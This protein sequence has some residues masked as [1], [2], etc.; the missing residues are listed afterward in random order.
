M[1]TSEEIKKG[2]ECCAARYKC[3][4]CPYNESDT[5]RGW[6]CNVKLNEDLL[7]YVQRLETE[8]D[9]VKRERDAAVEAAQPKWISVE[10][11]LPDDEVIAANFAPGTYGYKECILGYVGRDDEVYLREKRVVYCAINDYE[12]LRNVTHWMPLPPALN[13]KKEE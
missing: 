6:G 4:E 11:R 8:C 5:G 3:W 12:I 10:E 2:L 13:D 9:R 1:K 7:E